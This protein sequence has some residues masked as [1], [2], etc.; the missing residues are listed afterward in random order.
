MQDSKLRVRREYIQVSTEPFNLPKLDSAE[1]IATLETPSGQPY[2]CVPQDPPHKITG[3][4]AAFNY[5]VKS[6]EADPAI[7]SFML[8]FRDAGND[9]GGSV[10]CGY[11]PEQVPRNFVRLWMLL[12]MYVLDNHFTC[13]HIYVA[14]L[15]AVLC[16]L[17]GTMSVLHSHQTLPPIRIDPS[18]LH[19]HMCTLQ[20]CL[21]HSPPL[22]SL[23][24]LS[25][26][27]SSEES[28]DIVQKLWSCR[29]AERTG[30][31]KR[32]LRKKC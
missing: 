9:F 14:V 19:K 26:S 17:R 30:G 1:S 2:L 16:C 25:P 11:V 3:S 29:T 15:T 31:R 8:G 7:V 32:G 5:P 20:R 10:T 18:V 12:G 27:A 6:P 13:L 22:Q 28:S 21:K 23:V 4:F 24:I